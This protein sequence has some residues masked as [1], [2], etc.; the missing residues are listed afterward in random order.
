[1]KAVGSESKTQHHFHCWDLPRCCE[2]FKRD[3]KLDVIEFI[4]DT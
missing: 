1:M 3:I 4:K 2:S